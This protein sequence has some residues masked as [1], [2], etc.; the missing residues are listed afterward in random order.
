M[1]TF[2]I[3]NYI[4]EYLKNNQQS[5]IGLNKTQIAKKI[6]DDDTTI[7]IYYENRFGTFRTTVNNLI[8]KQQ[9]IITVTNKN[10]PQELKT[11]YKVYNDKYYFYPIKGE[12]QLPINIVDELFYSYSNH[13]LDLS[14]TEMLLKFDLQPWQ[15]FAIKNA[16]RLYK[17]SHIF[18]PFT[19]ENTSPDK[20]TEMISQKM[21]EHI[22]KISTKV[23]N[24]YENS[25]FKKYKEVISKD[26]LRD[27]EI[28][29][30]IT[31]LVDYIPEANIQPIH[32]IYD[33]KTRLE[34]INVVI[35]DIHFGAKNHNSLLPEYSVDKCK[36]YFQSMIKDI[37][38]LQAKKVNIFFAG[39]LIES[40]TGLNHIDSWK[41]IQEGY[42]GANLIKECYHVLVNFI[43]E[44]NNI[45]KI[46]GVSGNHDR[47]TSKKDEDSEGFIAEIIFEF[48]SLSFKNCED[49]KIIFDKKLESIVIDGI[50][51]ILTH[52]DKKLTENA[53]NLILKFGEQ[54]MFNILLSGHWHERRIKSDTNEFRQLVC[55]SIFPG[56][57]YSVD[58]GYSTQPGF[59]II[60]NNGKGK[61]NVYDI[62]L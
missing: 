20:M 33:S 8:V 32:K 25:I 44:I 7:S 38:S 9:K 18:S 51:Y 15:W 35:A 42:Y 54:K 11:P 41:G 5:F 60:E 53:S 16:L 61:P 24:E 28:K 37:N 57:N 56:N 48:L 52:G 1:A 14:S 22:N 6:F 19:A 13:G 23:K 47:A 26:A 21:D 43:S 46:I 59:L 27:L 36:E 40:F 34:E 30:I 12:F 62:S 10:Q 31:E 2:S 58:L 29:T 17:A 39:D 4:S 49:V 50:C 3:Y 45:S 55:P